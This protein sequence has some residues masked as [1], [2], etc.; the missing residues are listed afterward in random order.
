MY[1]KYGELITNFMAT[2]QSHYVEQQDDATYRKKAGVVNPELI[3]QV[4][5]NQKSIAIYQKNNDLTI[6]WICFDFD[7][8]KS[9]IDSGLIHSGEKELEKTINVFCHTLEQRG[10]PFLLEYSGNRGFHVWITFSEV[11]NYRTGFDIQQAI[12]QDVGLDFDSN[13]IGIDLFPHSATPTGGVGLGVKIPLSKHRKSGCY[14]YLLPNRT[15][16]GNVQKLSSLSDTMLSDNIKILEEHSSIS[17]SALEKCLGIFFESYESENAQYNRIKSIKVQRKPFNLQAL[18]DLWNGTKPLNK[19]SLKIGLSENLT[20][21]ERV[22]IV[23]LLCNLECRDEPN[24]SSIILHEIFSKLDNYD[25]KITDSAIQALKNFNF[26][27]QDRIESTLSCKFDDTLSVEELIRVCVPNFLEYTEANFEFSN[28]DIEITRA[29]ELNYLFM[30]DEVQ[31]KVVVE[32]LSSKDNSEFLTEMDEFI[33]GLKTWSYYKHVRNEEGKT[34]ELITLDSSTR[35]MTSCILKQIAYYLDI[36]PDSNSHGYQINKGFEGGYIFKPWLY[37]WLK[38]I[39]NITDAI[40]SDVYKDYYIVKTDISSFY[41]NISHDRLKR[42]L[43]GDSDSAIKDKVESMRNETSDRY[44]KCLSAIFNMTQDIVGDNK[45]LPQG[46]AYARFFAELYLFE[47]DMGF[48]SKLVNSEILLYERYVDDIFFVTKSKDEAEKLLSGLSNNLGLLSLTLNNDKTVVSKISSFHNKFDRYRSQSKYAVD[49]VSKTF[50]TSTEKQ[51]NNAINEFVT[52]VQSDSCQEDLSFIFSHLDGVEELNVM[53]TEQILPAL[54]RAIGRGSLFKNLFN[55]LFEMNEGWEVIYKIEKFD[56]LQ[57]EVLTSCLINAIETNKG[58]RYTLKNIIE[59]IEPKLTYSRIVYE[60]IAY[61]ITNFSINV[62]ISK[63]P[64]EYYLSALISISDY[65]KVNA[66]NELISHLDIY[67]NEIRSSKNFI[68]VIYSFC[69][70]DNEVDLKKIASLFF[71][72]MSVEEKKNT[73]SI[74][75]VDKSI[76]DP[77]TTKKFYYLLCLFSVSREN[78]STDLLESMWKYCALSFNLFPCSNGSFSAPNWLEKLDQ[79]EIDNDIANWIISSIVDGNIFRGLSD[80]KKVFEQYHNAL[81]VYLSIENGDWNK[82]T[83]VSQL[84]ELK[85]KSTFYEWLIDN[86]GVSIFPKDNK[87]WFERN[88]IENGTTTL[89]KDNKI[90]IRKPSHLFLS[91]KDELEHYNGFSEVIVDYDREKLITFRRYVDNVDINSRFEL[92]TKFLKT[93]QEGDPIPSIFCPERVMKSDA[94]SVFSKEFCYHSKIISY[95]E[96]GN[97]TSYENS[98]N[99][100]INSFLSYIS[101]SDATTKKLK[102]K[103]ISNLDMDIDKVQ[104]LIKFYSQITNEVNDGSD[105][106]FDVAMATSLYIYLSNLD[107]ITRLERFSKQYSSFHNEVH[108]QHIF[109]VEDD[110]EIDDSNLH[111]ILF[112]I[113]KSLSKI[114]KEL[115]ITI[116]F[117]LHEDIF[118]YIEI[119]KEQIANSQLE[120]DSITLEDFKLSQVNAFLT[121]RTVKIDTQS[122]TFN[123]VLIVNPKLKEVASFEMKHLALINGSEHIYACKSGEY[124]YIISLANCLSVMYST[125]SER[126]SVLIEEK[127]LGHSYPSITSSAGD[128]TSLNGF[129]DASLIVKHHNCISLLEAENRLTNWLHHLPK[130][131]HQPLITLIRS[132]ECMQENEIQKFIDKVKELNAL[133]SNLFLIKNVADYNGTHRILYRDNEIGRGVATFTPRSLTKDSKQ[134]TLVTDLVLTGYQMKRALEF[135]LKGEGSRPNDNYFDFTEEDHTNLFDTFS[136]LEVLNICTVLYTKDAIHKIQ[137]ALQTILGNQITVNVEH[138]RDIGDN[139]FFGS[140]TKINQHEKSIIMDLLLDEFSLSD[141]YDHLSYSGTYPKYKDKNEVNKMNLVVRYQ[142]LPKKSFSFLTC[143]TKQEE[144]CKPFNRILELTDK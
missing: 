85:T 66:T 5:L 11:V 127:K 56:T 63:I 94:F 68:K 67:L 98:V 101:E 95:D 64:P 129:D 7:I 79:A 124:V 118:T 42:L 105:F 135:Y 47:I 57:S 73:F 40:E 53:K 60:H 8:L 140:T 50:F 9:C 59:A 108:S 89:C 103:Y 114:G 48:K 2:D 54:E 90:L 14:S 18:L 61:L 49:Q 45:G 133:N 30:N 3:K 78:R 131:F 93:L 44:K 43:L 136:E 104:F 142:S 116:P 134:A 97:V 6:R 24:L 83:I 125:L 74:L 19:L 41:D 75:N 91:D 107:P 28:K 25:E 80:E 115:L 27:T 100:F 111:S 29:A 86:D 72:K 12:L 123:N 32:E 106:F 4:L 92:L 96:F 1:K 88:I 62:E 39:S 113:Q 15:D 22:L 16:V 141:L 143:S 81:L 119:I 69:F 138:G 121:S 31:V 65:R 55:F 82:D 33:K 102:E 23:G 117:H 51:K 17:R 58:N 71:A 87:K 35:V 126:Y 52:L 122:Y 99:S 132:H 130:K 10:I 110:M 36:K 46:P 77:I 26:P 120:K 112:C 139:A 38:F 13:L 34:R 20:H 128:I 21:K 144:H 109:I 76:F 37:L 137:E 70:N 84:K